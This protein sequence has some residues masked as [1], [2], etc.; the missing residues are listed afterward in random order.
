MDQEPPD[1]ETGLFDLTSFDLSEVDALGN[2]A[3][4]EVLH[5]IMRRV[6]HP[7]EVAGFDSNV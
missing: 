4:A 3:L 5:Q 7:G 6:Q 2:S 1:I